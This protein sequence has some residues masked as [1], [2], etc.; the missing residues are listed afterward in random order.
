VCSC[1][2][3]LVCSCARVLVCSCARVLVCSF[4]ADKEM[5]KAL[6]EVEFDEWKIKARSVCQ[7]CPVGSLPVFKAGSTA[8]EYK[9][10][11]QAKFQYNEWDN[12]IVRTA[13]NLRRMHKVMLTLTLT[14]TLS[15]LFALRLSTFAVADIRHN[16]SNP[17]QSLACTTSVRCWK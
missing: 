14:R 17:Q 13:K 7:P 6:E 4:R 9:A 8:E 2:R 1:A 12:E 11:M 15:F 5:K 16:R 3:V 10:Y